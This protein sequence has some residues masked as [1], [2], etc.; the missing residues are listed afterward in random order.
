[1]FHLNAAKLR[2]YL[3]DKVADKL[4]ELRFSELDKINSAKRIHYFNDDIEFVAWIIANHIPRGIQEII[5]IIIVLSFV[6]HSNILIFLILAIFCGVF[7]FLSKR[8]ISTVKTVSTEI[9]KRRIEI[10]KFM[11]EGI[12][13]TR[14]IVSYCRTEWENNRFNPLYSNYLSQKILEGKLIVRQTNIGLLIDWGSKILIL[15]YGGY[16]VFNNKLTIG[17]LVVILQFTSILVES[18]PKVS[19]LYLELVRQAPYFIRLNQLL[20]ISSNNSKG[21]RLSE[22]LQCVLFEDVYFKYNETDTYVLKGINVKLPLNKKIAIVGLSGSGKST[23]LKLLLDF[24]KPTAG[25][26]RINNINL[27]DLNKKEWM[28]NISIVFQEPHIFTDTIKNNLLLDRTNVTEDEIKQI[29][30]KLNF[31]NFI[32]SLPGGYDT[33]IGNNGINLSGG[34]RQKLSIARALLSK[35]PIMIMDE[36]TSALDVQSEISIQNEI[37]SIRKGKTTIFIAHRLSTIKNADFI[38]VLDNGHIVGE[39][40]HESLI[41]NNLTYKNL[42]ES[43]LGLA[44]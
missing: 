34:Q 39:G 12:L 10:T 18:V 22:E 6:A 32:E 37:D 25:K 17:S 24:Y 33:Y 31:H 11:E 23:I 21:I 38:I 28:K 41:E 15:A 4:G 5:K 13:S 3:A 1:M 19:K 2:V 42:V 27:D 20:N 7:L 35:S 40:T 30:K 16:L 44:K 26:I 43:E 14:E 36:S 29:C 9:M 8:Y